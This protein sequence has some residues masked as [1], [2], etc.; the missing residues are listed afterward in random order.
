MQA[1]VKIDENFYSS[2]CSVR[3][4]SDFL[5]RVDFRDS[6]HHVHAIRKMQNDLRSFDCT[7]FR[8]G[9]TNGSLVNRTGWHWVAKPEISGHAR[10]AISTMDRSLQTQ[11]SPEYQR[12]SRSS[13]V[14]P[15][16]SS[17]R[18][19][20]VETRREVGT[21]REN[22]N[23]QGEVRSTSR[24]GE[25]EQARG[26]SSLLHEPWTKVRG[27]NRI[28]ETDLSILRRHFL[29]LRLLHHLCR[30]TK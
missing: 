2:P 15:L 17:L 28:G 22:V 6:Q 25:R 8:R 13:I 19:I 9:K 3:S 29:F 20:V 24:G 4:R 1:V 18:V 11:P 26:W 23:K 14:Q 27:R 7:C 21:L 5:S 12:T 10:Y 16:R 30:Q